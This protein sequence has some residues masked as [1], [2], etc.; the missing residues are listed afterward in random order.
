VTF[1]THQVRVEKDDYK[2]NARVVNVQSAQVTVPFRLEPS[3]VSGKCN[4]LG[5]AGAAVS[6][7][8]KNVGSLP[9][10]VACTPGSHT[11]VVTPADGAAFTTSRAVSFASAG[12]TATIFLSP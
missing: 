9:L 2:A 11:F 7:D 5:T 4:L 12:E 6:M 8:G 1:G 10:T 3:R